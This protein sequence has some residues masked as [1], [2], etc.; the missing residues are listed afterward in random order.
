[1]Y[2]LAY[3]MNTNLDQMSSRCPAAKSLGSVVLPNHR[4]AFK[5]CCDVIVD[6]NST[7]ECALW[8]ITDECERAL[9]ILEGYPNFYGKKEVKV[10]HKGRKIR[11]MIYYMRDIDRLD[12]PG[13]SYLNMVAEGYFD[14]G[15]D[16][17]QIE[18]AIEDVEDVYYSR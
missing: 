7:M 14:H 11:A 17:T 9:D 1:M 4:L 13:E 3:G 5:G 10:W 2:Y 12:F 16:I 8:D 15:M 18:K 6:E